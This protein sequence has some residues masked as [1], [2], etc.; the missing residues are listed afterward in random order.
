MYVYSIGINRDTRCY[1]EFSVT[2]HKGVKMKTTRFVRTVSVRGLLAVLLLIAA[3]TARMPAQTDPVVNLT[4]DVQLIDVDVFYLSDAAFNMQNLVT[5]PAGPILFSMTITADRQTALAL[6]IRIVAE[7]GLV[8]EPIDIFNGI[9][10]PVSFEPNI[11]RFFTN[12]DMGKGG[13]LELTDFGLINIVDPS[14]ATRRVVDVIRGS[15]KLPEGTYSLEMT[16]YLPAS[17]EPPYGPYF[18]LTS[19]ERH[20]NIVNPSQVELLSPFDGDRIVSQFPL[21]QWRSD[22]RETVLRVFEVPAGSRS[23]EEAVSGIPHLET[24]IPNANQFFYPQSG[25]G[26]RSL[27][28]GKNY[29]WYV[30][31][32]YRTSANIEEAIV[33]EIYEFTLVD[34]A[35]FSSGDLL[36]MQLEQLLGDRFEEILVRIQQANLE[37]TGELFLDGIPISSAEFTMIIDAI[38]TRKFNAEVVNVTIEE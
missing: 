15:G 18:E 25:P 14:P 37:F 21:F 30:E 24:R 34:P 10:K 38:R 1:Y 3:V 26:I 32:V 2:L 28:P 6:G 36:L 19:V 22:T 31:A 27:E 12:R 17:T 29:V 4:F 35:S 11:P 7:T 33:S 9:T 8:Q 16:A 5:S 23:R 13:P 20:L